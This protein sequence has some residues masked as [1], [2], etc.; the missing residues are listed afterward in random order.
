MIKKKLD[1]NAAALLAL[2]LGFMR[3]FYT[4]II[5]VKGCE[6]ELVVNRGQLRAFVELIC[7]SHFFDLESSASANFQDPIATFFA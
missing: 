3:L 2:F 5:T 7:A 4:L 6:C 1:G